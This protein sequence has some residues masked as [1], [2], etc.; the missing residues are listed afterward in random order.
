MEKS[1]LRERFKILAKDFFVRHETEA[2]ERIHAQIAAAL[3][4]YASTSLAAAQRQSPCVAV[5]EPFK[6]ELPA[7]AIV[8]SSGAFANPLFVYPQADGESMWFSDEHGAGAEPDIIIVPGLFVDRNGNRLGRGKGY[9][10]RYLRSRQL[11]LELRIFLGYPFQF[12]DTVP[13]D[14]RDERV[15]PIVLPNV[16]L[17]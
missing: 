13:T 4:Q 11:P 6:V 15:T 14:E 9:Y 12:I 17:P 3:K 1:Q 8:S 7:R 5:Y 10:D 16:L 2:L